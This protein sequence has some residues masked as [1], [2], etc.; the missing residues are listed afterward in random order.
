MGITAITDTDL[1]NKRLISGIEREVFPPSSVIAGVL[2][3]AMA[4]FVVVVIVFILWRRGTEVA[5]ITLEKDCEMSPQ[6]LS[7]DIEN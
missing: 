4:I 7:P 1:E 5:Y 6:S 2:V 3:L